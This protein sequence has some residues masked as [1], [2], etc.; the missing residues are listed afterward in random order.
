MK[1]PLLMVLLILLIAAALAPAFQL[2]EV[3]GASGSSSNVGAGSLLGYEQQVVSSVNGSGA[4]DYD[5]ELEKISY[6][7]PDFRSSGSSGAFE[8]ANS[9]KG[10][11]ESF[12]LQ[13]WLEPF[14]F[15]NWTLLNNAS[16]VIDL[17]GNPDT[18]SDQTSVSSFQCEHLSWPTPTN[19]VLAS[20]IVLPLPAISDRSQIGMVPINTTLWNSINT[21]GKVV[22]VG[23]EVRSHPNW[24]NPYASKLS[25][26]PPAAVVHTWWYSWDSFI[27]PFFSSGGGV[28]MNGGYYWNSGIPVGFVDYGAGLW[29]N[30]SKSTHPS[31]AA[32][33][34]IPAVINST[35][36]HYNVVGK[37]SGLQ[38]PNKLV[39]VSA[40]YDTVMCSGFC[41]NGAGTAGIVELAKVFSEAN[42]SGVYQ[43]NYTLLFVDFA[44]EEYYLVG[45]ANYVKQHKSDM[46]NI[47]AVINL[48][49][50]GSD[51]LYVSETPG[52]SLASTIVQAAQDLSISITTESPGDS[53]H[54][55]FRSP[56]YVDNVVQSCWGVDLGISDAT[57]VA[58]SSMLD[59]YPLFYS[60]LWN[61]GTPGWI[62][63]AYDNST[64]TSTLNWVE[65]TDLGNH[66][67]VAALTLMR[68]S[69]NF[70]PDFTPRI[71]LVLLMSATLVAC[72]LI[73][74]VRRSRIE[75]SCNVREENY[76]S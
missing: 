9:I 18:V 7:H 38:D 64:S 53:D 70:V 58:A 24:A 42:Q 72:V 63:T 31:L 73:R 40:H 26:Q 55:T 37:I 56:S 67:K 30:S 39:I 66:I 10:M 28:P 16:L 20:L 61:M 50:I 11:F 54:E 36:T 47:A 76:R 74:K 2:A 27:P 6:S 48:D 33:V 62:H 22:L 68:V 14:Q 23:R 32:N 21:T 60:D 51:D 59:S 15:T 71:A 43:P 57:P 49:C 5:L 34:T 12:G 44:G 4:Y 75:R 45:S 35:G 41:D 52:S 3:R 29:I 17:D 1:R 65:R 8:A 25:L 13:S 19:G 69:P 46:A